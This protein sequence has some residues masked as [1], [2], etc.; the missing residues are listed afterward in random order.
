MP[1]H[2]DGAA[3]HR[4]INALTSRPYRGVNTL[5][6]W[7]GG[8]ARDVAS[9]ARPSGGTCKGKMVGPANSGEAGFSWSGPTAGR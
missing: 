8:Q 5:A 1:W 3:I 9:S 2:H 7:A 4:P 6:L